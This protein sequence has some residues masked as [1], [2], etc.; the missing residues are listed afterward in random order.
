MVFKSTTNLYPNTYLPKSTCAQAPTNQ[1]GIFLIPLLLFMKI[2]VSAI[3]LSAF[4]YSALALKSQGLHLCRVLHTEYQHQLSLSLNKLLKL[5]PKALRLRR[6][7]WL[8]IGRLKRAYA[9]GS[10]PLIAAAQAHH[11]RITMRQIR[12]HSQQKQILAQMAQIK[13]HY[14]QRLKNQFT[15]KKGLYNFNSGLHKPLPALWR[16]PISSLSPSYLTPPLY[17]QQVAVKSYWHF[18]PTKL[19]PKNLQTFIY[20]QIYKPSDIKSVCAS[21]IHK[22]NNKWTGIAVGDRFL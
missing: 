10:L 1:E 9:S 7:K 12:F 21:T 17:T 8:A 5:N 14:H 6:Q 15:Q 13:R 18:Q 11:S 16:K 3:F 4:A 22:R 2:V 20:S 19:L